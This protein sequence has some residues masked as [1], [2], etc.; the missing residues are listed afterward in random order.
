MLST[1]T[2]VALPSLGFWEQL[3]DLEAS[4]PAPWE[5]GRAGRGRGGAGSPWK[6]QHGGELACLGA[7]PGPAWAGVPGQATA[8]LSCGASVE[9][10][11]GHTSVEEERV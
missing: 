4:P 5:R 1:V 10:R 11:G 8:L 2:V 7:A 6:A 3:A 9:L